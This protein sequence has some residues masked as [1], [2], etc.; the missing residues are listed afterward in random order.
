M[1]L[2]RLV[3]NDDYGDEVNANGLEHS[4]EIGWV[5][6]AYVK[7]VQVVSQVK[8]VQE[9]DHILASKLKQPQSEASSYL[10][11]DCGLRI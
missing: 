3:L 8:N 7:Q 4:H 11:P 6:P 5:E 1:T 2:T 10:A 9:V